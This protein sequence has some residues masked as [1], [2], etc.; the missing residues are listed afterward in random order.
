MRQNQTLPWQKHITNTPDWWAMAQR[1]CTQGLCGSYSSATHHSI[2][3][4]RGEGRRRDGDR[5]TVSERGREISFSSD[6]QQH[7]L[8]HVTHMRMSHVTQWYLLLRG[9][10][11][12]VSLS[13]S[14]SLSHTH[15]HTHTH[16]LICWVNQWYIFANEVYWQQV[17]VRTGFSVWSNFCPG[18]QKTVLGSLLYLLFLSIIITKKI[19]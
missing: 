11:M 7:L 13:L 12:R 14:L 6:R 17:W 10:L 18:N 19:H 5:E 1:I 9:P 2:E 3:T 4:K 8:W 16:T 15:T